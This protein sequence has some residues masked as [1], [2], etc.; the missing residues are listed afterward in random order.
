MAKKKIPELKIEM[1][2]SS[3]NY[4][5]ISLLEYR[6]EQYLCIIDNISET[7][8]GAYVLDFAEQ[9]NIFVPDF[10]TLV[11]NWFYSNSEKHPLSI[12]LSTLG[13]TQT[14]SPIYKTFEALYVS[15][16]IGHAFS[17]SKMNTSK[18]RRRRVIS[19]QEHEEI[20]FKKS[21]VV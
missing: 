21:N 11:T 9:S 17:Y 19:P 4:K 1:V 6:R 7:E 5:F 13:L 12:E 3:A 14:F 2:N 18:V 20:K 10:L 8:I 15:R 16:I